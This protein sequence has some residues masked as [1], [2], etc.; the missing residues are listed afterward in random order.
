MNV[1]IIHDGNCHKKINN[2]AH[3]LYF[4]LKIRIS[5]CRGEYTRDR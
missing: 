5:Q 4:A 1:T 2:Q 3:Q